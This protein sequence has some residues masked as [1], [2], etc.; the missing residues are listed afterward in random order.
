MKRSTTAYFLG[1]ADLQLNLRRSKT[2]DDVLIPPSV[3]GN[4]SLSLSLSFLGPLPSGD[5]SLSQLNPPPPPP[6][7]SPLAT[8]NLSQ[9]LSEQQN[10][11][12]SKPTGRIR[13]TEGTGYGVTIRHDFSGGIRDVGAPGVGQGQGE[14]QVCPGR[15]SN[16]RRC[17]SKEPCATITSI[18]DPRLMHNLLP[19]ARRL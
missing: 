6:F 18:R 14:R 8:H 10:Q 17:G 13:A 12:T 19:G 16:Q 2:L 5:T 15:G 9:T 7:P 3:E 4:T 11:V 1:E